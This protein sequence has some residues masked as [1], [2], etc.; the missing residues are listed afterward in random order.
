MLKEKNKDIN[1]EVLTFLQDDSS[2]SFEPNYQ[3]KFLKVLVED[4]NNWCQQ[5]AD[6]LFPE[7]F[8]GYHQI[9]VNYQIEY[10]RKYRMQ[11]DYDDMKDLVEDGEK[12]GIVKEHLNGLIDKIKIMELEHQRRQ[13]VKDRAYKYF[14]SRKI[15][16][17]LIELA[18]DWKNQ[19]YESMKKK[20]EDA[21]KAGEPKDIG[22]NYLLD[23]ESRLKK[24][25]RNPI[26]AVPGLDSFLGGGL[27]PGEE[28][29]VLAPPG[30]GKSMLLVRFA[31]SALL[32]G[33][34]I[35]YYS[36]E[37]SEKVIGQRFDSCLNGIALKEVWHFK[38][39]IKEKTDELI[40]LKAGL[41][42][43]EYPTG[44]ATINTL[45]S[46][47]DTLAS[48]E[49]FIP[50][51]IFIDYADIMK[52]T[53][54]YTDKRHTLTGVYEEIRGMA[55]ELRVPIWTASQTNRGAMQQETFGLDAIGESLGKAATADVVIGVARP[56]KTKN[57]NVAKIGILK[58]RNGADGMHLDFRFDTSKIEI[59]YMEPNLD[60]KVDMANMCIGNNNNN[61]S[62]GNNNYN[63]NNNNNNNNNNNYNNYNN[64][65]K[66]AVNHQIT[67]ILAAQ[68]S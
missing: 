62:Y 54:T 34:K 18:G 27:A 10:F 49:D 57:N 19:T 32:A 17:T 24:D 2:E 30:G 58:N 43:K 37:L 50:D 68:K 16:N 11:A 59:E 66:Q 23:V 15:K 47:L 39:I 25:Y 51:I 40:N 33:K 63:S 65:N 52:P 14:K 22:H 60:Q 44:H 29:I 38:D 56:D 3:S 35:V 7:Y 31:V 21:L 4:K 53:I 12:D 36:M 8:E 55:V 13:S 1:K 9:L 41:I 46:H 20:I 28:G 67:G 42:I 6:I 45:Y 5:I 61:K 64:N 26:S 48:N